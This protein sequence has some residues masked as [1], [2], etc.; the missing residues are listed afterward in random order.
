MSCLKHTQRKRKDCPD[1]FPELA[2]NIVVTEEIT[3]TIVNE[4]RAKEIIENIQEKE[5]AEESCEHNVTVSSLM[6]EPS[7]EVNFDEYQDF[8]HQEMIKEID[9]IVAKKLKDVEKEINKLLSIRHESLDI[10]L[11]R[12]NL[13]VLDVLLND[14]WKLISFLTK[15]AAKISGLKEDSVILQRIKCDLW[16]KTQ[17]QYKQIYKDQK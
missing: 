13:K 16:K 15:D 7:I 17:E 8:K 11:A 5:I 6:E 12:F 4:E 9:T 14:G 3:T 10:P 1:C 2:T